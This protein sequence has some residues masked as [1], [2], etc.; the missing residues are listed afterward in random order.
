MKL[1]FQYHQVKIWF[2]NR[3]YKCKRQLSDKPLDSSNS[4]ATSPEPGTATT[5][6]RKMTEDTMITSTGVVGTPSEPE[7]SILYQHTSNDPLV[8]QQQ[9]H[10]VLP[11][12]STLYSHQQHHPSSS[13][14]S[15]V[16]S[17][18]HHHQDM[19]YSG[20]PAE[21]SGYYTLMGGNGVNNVSAAGVAGQN[22]HQHSFSSSVRA[23]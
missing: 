5:P 14:Y 1:S 20:A 6:L 7:E 10:P 19:G 12:Y 9:Q 21:S 8:Q 11:P 18:Y 3:R 23:W 16:P 15:N 13:G 2:Q 17:S 4:I 22:F